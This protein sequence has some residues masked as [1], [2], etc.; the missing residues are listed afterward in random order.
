MEFVCVVGEFVRS[1]NVSIVQ[2]LDARPGAGGRS[3]RN[4]AALE[5]ISGRN[6]WCF[7]S[8]STGEQQEREPYCSDSV[9][10]PSRTGHHPQPDA[11]TRPFSRAEGHESR[12]CTLVR[13]G[14]ILV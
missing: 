14:A 11:G 6:G 3:K 4:G 13:F 2:A 10:D 12:S 5:S 7:L 8:R 1:S 9:Y